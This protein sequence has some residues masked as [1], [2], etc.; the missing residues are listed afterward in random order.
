MALADGAILADD[1]SIEVHDNCQ[2]SA[3]PVIRDVPDD[4]HRPTGSAMFDELSD[5]QQDQLLGPDK[6]HLVR[7]GDVPFHALVARSPMNA[8]PDQ[9]TEA[10]LEALHAH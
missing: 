9:I 1:S 3:E 2:C 4:I 8:I 6:A 5:E 7:N 10:P